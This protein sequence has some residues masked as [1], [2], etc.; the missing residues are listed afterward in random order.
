MLGQMIYNMLE[1][2]SCSSQVDLTNM[3]EMVSQITSDGQGPTA[4]PR[5]LYFLPLALPFV[6]SPSSLAKPPETS[7]SRATELINLNR[8]GPSLTPPY[9]RVT[10]TIT[11]QTSINCM[12]W[13]SL[14]PAAD[15]PSSSESWIVVAVPVCAFVVFILQAVML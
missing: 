3:L 2:K 8:S 14:P 4:A 9:H 7:A 5:V 10:T 1:D 15:S 12:R 11:F 13:S 6:F